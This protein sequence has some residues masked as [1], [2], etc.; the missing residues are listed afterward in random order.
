V[1][2]IGELVYRLYAEKKQSVLV[3]LQGID[4]AGKDGTIRSILSEVNPLGIS[5]ASFKKPTE[6]ELGH[7]FLWRIHKEV[8]GKGELRIFNR[9][10]YE[11]VLVVRVHK[12]VEKKV[13]KERYEQI[14]AFEKFLSI[15]GTKVLKFFLHISKEEQKARLKSRLSD[16]TRR[17]KFAVGDLE[18]RKLWDGYIEAY[19]DALTK[20]NTEYAPWHI[21]PAD[22]KWYRNLLI[23]RTVRT[24]LEELNPQFP[25]HVEG[26]ESIE[27]D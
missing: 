23:S 22:R 20:C 16:P 26:I 17:W 19:D 24:A 8:P 14:N 15:S 9:S 25:Q 1:T 10:H 27:F 5:I 6:E 7:D 21:V 4:T 12:L 18:E 2:K 13:W 3:V 11:D